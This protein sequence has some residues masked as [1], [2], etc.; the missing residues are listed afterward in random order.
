VRTSK[1]TT[2]KIRAPLATIAS[3]STVGSASRA[4]IKRSPSTMRT[5][6]KIAALVLG[7]LLLAGFASAC[8]G[9]TATS[10]NSETH[11]L[12]SCAG[13][14]SGGLECICGVCSKR[15]T[16]TSACGDLSAD[17]Q[18]SDSCDGPTAKMCDLP[19]TNSANCS[20]LGSGFVCDGGHCR[21]GSSGSGG[22]GG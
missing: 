3:R 8:D 5:T 4:K 20:A 2:T 19:C 13:S 1:T 9:K 7:S 21:Q 15:C 16:E 11:F 17:A 22:N 6:S 10:D 14:C 18:C 12:G